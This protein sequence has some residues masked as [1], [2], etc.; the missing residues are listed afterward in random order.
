MTCSNSPAETAIPVRAERVRNI[1]L[2]WAELRKIYVLN[3][4]QRMQHPLH[5]LVF[6]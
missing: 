4:N 3:E 6:I 1:S 2:Q 5:P